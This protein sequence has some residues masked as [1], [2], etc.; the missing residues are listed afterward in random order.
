MKKIVSVVIA[1][2]MLLIMT[3]SVAALPA[4]SAGGNVGS[5]LP[6]DYNVPCDF[7]WSLNT[8]D[9]DVI[10]SESSD[11]LQ[12]GRHLRKFQFYYHAISQLRLDN[13]RRN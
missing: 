9:G 12:F 6:V 4:P 8:I 10:T 13:E 1:A 7:E 3:A 2:V 11:F 5:A